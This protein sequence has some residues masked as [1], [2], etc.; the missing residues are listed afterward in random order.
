MK[1]AFTVYNTKKVATTSIMFESKCSL[2]QDVTVTAAA[3]AAMIEKEQHTYCCDDYLQPL[4]DVQDVVTP[5]DRKKL[6]DWCFAIVDACNFQRETVAIAMN[7]LDRFMSLWSE[8]SIT[9]LQSKRELQLVA[10]TSLYIGIKI[11]ERMAFSGDFFVTISRGG[12]SVQEIEETE[13]VML[14]GLSWRINGPT[15]LQL[16][17]HILSL[18]NVHELLDQDVKNCLID[19]VQYLTENAVRDYDLSISRPSTVALTTLF[20][21][22]QQLT[23]VERVELYLRVVPLVR[24]FDFEKS[25]KKSIAF[26]FMKCQMTRCDS[27]QSLDKFERDVM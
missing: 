26:R 6:V 2:S 8:E 16:A 25:S 18:L 11:N 15:P 19:E 14:R 22:F 5:E 21:S 27:A 12:Y 9:A 3:L 4:C 13:K 7:L 23:Y 17:M 1:E 20:R 10:V 24:E